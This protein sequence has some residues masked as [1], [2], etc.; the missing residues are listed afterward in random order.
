MRTINESMSRQSDLQWFES[1]RAVLAE[2]Y[3]GRWL[4]VHDG[5]IQS[6][7]EQEADAVNFAVEKFGIDVASVFLATAR[8]PVSFIGAKRI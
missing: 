3:R 1:N 2:Q 7:F 5:R 4:V 8:D 6:V